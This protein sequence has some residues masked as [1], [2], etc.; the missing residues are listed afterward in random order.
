[1]RGPL[2]NPPPHETMRP[3]DQLPLDNGDIQA[4]RGS[5][6]GD[7]TRFLEIVDQVSTRHHDPSL[8]EKPGLSVASMLIPL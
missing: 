7:R 5:G 8:R 6:V 2:G 1:M 4:V 3:E